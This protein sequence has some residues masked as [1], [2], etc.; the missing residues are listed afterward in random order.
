M[1]FTSLFKK[2]FNFTMVK[3]KREN[4]PFSYSLRRC[5]TEFPAEKRTAKDGNCGSGLF[6]G[7]KSMRKEFCAFPWMGR[8]VE[9]Y[10]RFGRT[11]AGDRFSATDSATGTELATL[12]ADHVGE[13]LFGLP[14]GLFEK[15][16][17]LQQEGAF[18]GGSD[19]ELSTRLMNLMETGA[20]EI[21][22]EATLKELEKEKRTLMA[23]DKRSN[24]GEL[25]HCRNL[26]EEKIRERYQLLSERNQREAEQE[27]LKNAEAQLKMAQEEE[28]FWQEKKMQKDRLSSMYLRKNKWEEARKMLQKAE[29]KEKSKA[30]LIFSSLTDEEIQKAEILEKKMETLDQSEEI[31]YDIKN[32]EEE[33][34]REKHKE[35]R[36]GILLL[37]GILL[38]VTSP[39]LFLV[40][41]ALSFL[42]VAVFLVG[43]ITLGFGFGQF[44]SARQRGWSA[45]ED[46]NQALQ[47]RATAQE[48]KAVLAS[49]Y[50]SLLA[51]YQCV[52]VKDLREGF[53]QCKQDRLE[54]EGYRR[55]AE[56]ILEGEDLNV[57]AEEVNQLV[58]LQEE[59]EELLQ[60]DVDQKLREL[61]QKQLEATSAMKEAEGK[62]SYVF[63]GARN[64][65]D[66]ETE[67][68]QLDEE[69]VRLEKKQKALEL[70]YSTFLEVYEKRKSD[71]TPLLNEQVNVFLRK[72]SGGT[73]WSSPHGG[74]LSDENSNRWYSWLW[75]RIF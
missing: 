75:G 50:H 14:E 35:T 54:A 5:S 74:R 34:N 60:T 70:A 69:I 22:A 71:F 26:R 12:T 59:E 41:S 6:R 18:I 4:P 42:S 58:S 37:A 33:I 8:E 48:E 20:E 68:Q 45:M 46:K 32:A 39:I 72:L 15:V 55:T 25:D 30:S 38:L 3:M 43:V 63:H 19:T 52:S 7:K 56:S 67:I 24:P 29:E 11:A 31:E 65:A 51:V 9:L 53:L 21:S 61:T 36:G 57:L 73:L 13:E 1:T 49:S 10:R 2:D 44:R 64:P 66:V 62:L 23:K 27:R 47:K 40:S 28:K 16:F 17:W